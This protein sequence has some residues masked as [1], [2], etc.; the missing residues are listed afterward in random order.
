MDGRAIGAQGGMNRL[1]RLGRPPEGRVDDL[2][3]RPGRDRQRRRLVR[4]AEAVGE[5]RRLPAP[6][7]RERW[8][9][10]ALE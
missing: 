2:E 7:G 5:E 8:I 9:R 10:L 3:G 1:G 6:G 4:S